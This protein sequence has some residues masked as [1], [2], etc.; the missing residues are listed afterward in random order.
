MHNIFN[1][2]KKKLKIL[3]K[4]LFKVFPLDIEKLSDL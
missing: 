2:N 4:V 3:Y 1:L